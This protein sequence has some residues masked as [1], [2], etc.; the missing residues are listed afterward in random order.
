MDLPL[1]KNDITDSESTF[2]MTDTLQ[3]AQANVFGEQP[4]PVCESSDKA[5]AVCSTKWFGRPLSFKPYF[6]NT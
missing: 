5:S 3:I 4:P 1:L 2:K 6:W